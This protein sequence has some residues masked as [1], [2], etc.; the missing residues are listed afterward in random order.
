LVIC[1]RNYIT[2]AQP[3]YLKGKKVFPQNEASLAELDMVSVVENL[4][5]ASS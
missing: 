4:S 3:P 5:E 2:A 1:P